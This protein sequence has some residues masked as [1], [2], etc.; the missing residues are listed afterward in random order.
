IDSTIYQQ[1][2]VMAES[3]TEPY[4]YTLN[5]GQPQND[6]TFTGL[7][8]GDYTVFVVDD[9]GCEASTTFRF[10]SSYDIKVPNFFTPN[11]DGY[12]DTWLIE[13]LE[14][15]PESIIYIYDRY[16]KLLKKYT[17]NDPAWNGEYLSRPVPS[18]DYWYVIHL[19]PVDKLIKGHFTLK[20]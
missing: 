6:P 11:G 8:N 15:L 5:N 12:N 1:I 13:G 3:G 2:V 19:L 14:K 7:G 20:R 17:S 9:K 4:S 16:G 10:E 18:D